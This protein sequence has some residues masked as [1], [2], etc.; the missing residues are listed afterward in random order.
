M[1]ING[2]HGWVSKDIVDAFDA[3]DAPELAAPAAPTPD[4]TATLIVKETPVPVW[5]IDED[6]WIDV[7]LSEQR[8]TAFTMQT[9]VKTYLVS[10]GLPQTPTPVG[11]YRIWIKFET[12]DMAGDDYF[13]EDVPWVMY[14]HEGYGL[15]GVTWH[16]NF[17]TRMSH[18]CVNQPT[19]MAEW[20]FNF[21]DEGTLVNVHE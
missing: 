1:E 8:V 12:D 2:E 10:T 3:Q 6:R 9:P 14:F 16:A 19:E 5:A 18:G 13:I 17:G 20:L 4:P 11:Q 15:H 7:D 21:A